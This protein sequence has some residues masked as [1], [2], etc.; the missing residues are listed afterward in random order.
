MH[1]TNSQV[2]AQ[3]Q[4]LFKHS[5]QQVNL[6]Q[7]LPNSSV[8]PTPAPQ[9][10]PSICPAPTDADDDIGSGAGLETSLLKALVEAMTGRRI[11]L[12]NVAQA[13]TGGEIGAA[14]TSAPTQPASGDNGRFLRVEATQIQE[15]EITQVAFSG[16]FNIADGRTISLNLQYVLQRSYSATTFSA[17]VSGANPKDP[18]V[19]NFDGLGVAL[20]PGGTQFDIDSDNVIDALPTLR[21]GSAYL[22]LDRNGDG[23]INNGSELFGAQ[24]GDGYGELAQFDVDGNLFIDEGD[25]IFAQLQLFRPGES[26]QSLSSMDIGAIFLG[27]AASPARLTDAN[28]QSLGQLRATGF[29]LTNAGTAGLVQQID[30]MT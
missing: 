5:E 17:S 3:G 20:D 25:A 26:A 16:E 28:N 13:A 11:S 19:L 18:L 10:P 27:N 1:I 30:L 8:A 24:S 22:A 21:A 12:L 9:Q 14:T 6:R 23:V 29:Y 4:H 2:K 15:M 7:R